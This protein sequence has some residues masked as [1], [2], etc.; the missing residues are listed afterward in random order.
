MFILTFT[1]SSPAY[2]FGFDIKRQW[3]RIR[4]ATL[5]IFIIVNQSHKKTKT[6][7]EFILR[8]LSVYVRP[9]MS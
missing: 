5:Y 6:N 2:S 7:K 3:Q 9:D 4:L 1:E 8:V